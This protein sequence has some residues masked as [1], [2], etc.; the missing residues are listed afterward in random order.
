MK[1]ATL[2]ALAASAAILSADCAPTAMANN[3]EAPERKLTKNKKKHKL[4]RDDIP[5]I[6]DIPASDSGKQPTEESDASASHK[7]ADERPAKESD[8]KS[9]KKEEEQ[10][11]AKEETE[12]SD[13]SEDEEEKEEKEESEDVDESAEDFWADVKAVSYYSNMVWQGAYQG[14]YSRGTPSFGAP[15]KECFGTW[16]GDDMKEI[17]SFFNGMFENFWTCE[18]ETAKQVSY[19]IVDLTFKNDEHCNFRE[20]FWD[21]YQFCGKD[22]DPCNW[23][24]L[25]D[26]VSTSA[27]SLITQISQ[28]I[29]VFKQQ[30]WGTMDEQQRGYAFKQLSSA[31]FKIAADLLAFKTTMRAK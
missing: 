6:S 15:Q 23:D 13:D 26:N 14:L 22:A 16:I 30:P 19:D 25:L 3:Q 1:L 28:S 10:S 27:F 18:F 4:P 24:K 7:E 31:G 17:D 11:E 8:D 2:C 20:T 5:D 9:P 21:V 12:E 29:A